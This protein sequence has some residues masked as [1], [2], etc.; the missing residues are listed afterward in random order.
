MSLA[1]IGAGNSLKSIQNHFSLLVT[2][3]SDDQ[4]VTMTSWRV[5][6][7]TR[8]HMLETRPRLSKEYIA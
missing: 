8:P 5:L 4:R 1:L 2:I 6:E 7:G 3:R